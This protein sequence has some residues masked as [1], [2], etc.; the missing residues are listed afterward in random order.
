MPI[1]KLSDCNSVALD[2][3]ASN[4]LSQYVGQV[5][6]VRGSN[7]C[8]FV[9]SIVGETEN[10]ES[11]QFQFFTCEECLGVPIYTLVKPQRYV[12]PGYKSSSCS[13][14]FVDKIKC[15]FVDVMFKRMKSALFSIKLSTKGNDKLLLQ[16]EELKLKL[17]Q[18][19]L[20]HLET[21]NDNCCK[22]FEFILNLNLSEEGT[23]SG[24]DCNG[25]DV[26]VYLEECNSSVELCFDINFE[27]ETVGDIEIIKKNDCRL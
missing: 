19:D 25:E 18:D 6:K 5:V 21:N 8:W 14:D 17:I 27:I 7:C 16:N 15:A 10:E 11:V 12:A 20:E 2:I 24:V 4:D 22:T 3:F 23:V 9:E 1:Y 13:T 26:T